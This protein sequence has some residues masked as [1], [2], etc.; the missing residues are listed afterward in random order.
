MNVVVC[1]PSEA[2]MPDFSGDGLTHWFAIQV[3]SNFEQTV[4]AILRNKGYEEFLPTYRSRRRWSDRVKEDHL[5]LFPGYVFCRLDQSKRLPILTTHGVVRIVGIGKTPAPVTA[6]ELESVWRITHSDLV[7]NPWPH[8][9]VGEAVFIESGPLTGMRGILVES[10]N[11]RRLVVSVSLLRRSVA[12]EIDEMHVRPVGGVERLIA[13]SLADI[14]RKGA[15]SA[16][17]SHP[18][19]EQPT[20]WQAH[21]V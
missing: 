3:R 2:E 16:P 13:R 7:A 17:L 1:N 15:A 10:K 8:L 20:G 11:H 12:V 5:P 6:D 21:R 4:S 14:P 18:L 9:E 19:T